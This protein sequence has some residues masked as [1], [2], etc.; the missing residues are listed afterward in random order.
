[1][2]RILWSIGVLAVLWVVLPVELPRSASG[3]SHAECLTLSDAPPEAAHAPVVEAFERCSALNPTD[4]QL[5][6]DLGWLRESSGQW[7]AAEAAYGRALEV[8]PGSAD[9]RVRL[10]RLLLKRGDID[11]AR[12]QAE[13]AR[14]VQPDRQTVLDFLEEMRGNAGH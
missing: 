14:R 10:A 4:V 9:L 12:R 1:M 6:A 11:G 3:V 8:D 13:A 7:G 2:T 5:L